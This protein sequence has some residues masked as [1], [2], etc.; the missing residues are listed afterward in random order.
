M[1][2]PSTSELFSVVGF[3]ICTEV[4]TVTENC[5]RVVQCFVQVSR[6][7]SHSCSDLGTGCAVGGT[8]TG[9][10]VFLEEQGTSLACLLWDAGH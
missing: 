7:F 2:P 1:L 8:S 9:H 3:L 6:L 10:G 4:F 5:P